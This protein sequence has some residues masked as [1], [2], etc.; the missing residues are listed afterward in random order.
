MPSCPPAILTGNNAISEDDTM[1]NKTSSERRKHF[2]YLDFGID[3]WVPQIIIARQTQA[4]DEMYPRY[5]ATHTYHPSHASVKRLVRLANKTRKANGES[6][7]LTARG[8]MI[9]GL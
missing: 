9:H 7:S 6:V 3:T 4:N 2:W 1:D 8:W 5:P